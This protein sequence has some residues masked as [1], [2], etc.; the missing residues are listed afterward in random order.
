MANH[1]VDPT[2]SG[3]APPGLR[4]SPAVDHASLGRYESLCA[5]STQEPFWLLAAR[6]VRVWMPL[7][8]GKVA[9]ACAAGSI[10]SERLDTDDGVV[11]FRLLCKKRRL[12]TRPF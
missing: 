10:T 1:R 11:E 7:K 12:P 3:L 4:L 9:H 6:E 8:K 2:T 5:T